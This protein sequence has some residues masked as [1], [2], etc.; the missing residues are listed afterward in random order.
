MFVLHIMESEL[1]SHQVGGFTGI[2]K[3]PLSISS[4][5]CG[6]PLTGKEIIYS[7][8]REKLKL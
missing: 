3:D 4:L 8:M 7:T 5:T 6:I 2:S 1:R